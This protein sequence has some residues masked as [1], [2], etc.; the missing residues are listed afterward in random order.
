VV[1]YFST[2][3]V[4]AL[5][6]RERELAVLRERFARNE[7]IVALATH[8]A[9]VAHELN[10]PLATMTLLSEEIA[11]QC[12]D[13]AIRE[14]ATT[15][16]EL[17]DICRDRVRELAASAEMGRNTGADLERVIHRWHLVRPTIE[18]QRE[19]ELPPRLRVD[20]SIGHLL[21][22]LLNNAADACPEGLQV[23]LDWN[24]ED[25]T[26]SI[27]D[28]GAG[29]PL[30]IAEQ[31]GKPFFTTKGKGFGLGLFLSKAS[32]TRAGGSVKLYSHEEGGTLTELRLPR[33]ARGDEHE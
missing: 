16:R 14:D 17:V 9:A 12:D 18:L 2:R 15:L 10:T 6:Q 30:A 26:I 25:L 1:L 7:G 22:A 27:R 11:E 24:A 31:I 33:V 4:A 28:H 8:A 5:R 20:P 3:L 29:V 23:T 13:E 32:V 19:G 21:Q